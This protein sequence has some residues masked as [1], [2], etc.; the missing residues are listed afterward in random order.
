MLKNLNNYK[1]YSEIVSESTEGE[2]E[3]V[4][5]RLVELAEEM[6]SLPDHEVFDDYGID[7]DYLIPVKKEEKDAN[8]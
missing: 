4:L 1:N 5:R 7:E 6:D 2:Q 8:Q 3:E